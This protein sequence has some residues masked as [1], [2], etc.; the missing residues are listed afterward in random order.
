MHSMEV[1]AAIT[2][3]DV[4]RYMHLK[5]FGTADPPG[6]VDPRSA[7]PNTLAVDKRQYRSSCQIVIIG[8]QQEWK[9][10]RLKV[11]R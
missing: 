1:L 3:N 6:D 4:L 2:P 10:I 5:T 9:G 7:R 11:C 8:V